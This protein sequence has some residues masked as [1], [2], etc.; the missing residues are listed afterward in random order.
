MKIGILTR[1]E[2]SWCSSQLIKALRKRNVESLCLNFSNLVAK[3]GELPYVS[4]REM[5]LLDELTALLVRPIGRCSTEEII[6]QMDLLH[7]LNRE[8]LIIINHPSAIEKAVDKYYTLS[9]LKDSGLPVPRTIATRSI[10]DAIRAFKDF[11]GE[12][13]VKPLFGSRGIG[14]ARISDADVAERVFRTLKFYRHVIYIQ[15]YIPHGN[16]D[17][18]TFVVGNEIISSM[19]RISDSWK[20]NISKGAKPTKMKIEG[21]I[22]EMSLRAA[23]AIG[24]EIAGVDLMETNK[25]LFILEVNSQPGWRGLQSISE[26]NIAGK[27]IDYVIQKCDR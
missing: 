18:R 15:E 22:K 11:G 16:K 19:R 2:E 6:F 10:K 25:G 12:A 4:F 27:I 21:D 9:L 13:I 8:G 24:C 1:N 3:V 20:T 23:K 14:T 7:K 26:V 17:V 5:D